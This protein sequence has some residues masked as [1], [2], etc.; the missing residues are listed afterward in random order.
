MLFIQGPNLFVVPIDFAFRP[1]PYSEH[2]PID[3]VLKTGDD[4]QQQH[5]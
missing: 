1:R 3:S 4:P 2:Y 5:Q